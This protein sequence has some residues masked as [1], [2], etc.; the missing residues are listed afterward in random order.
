MGVWTCAPARNKPSE[1]GKTENKSTIVTANSSDVVLADMS[2][3]P[4]CPLPFFC[5]HQNDSQTSWPA[6][7]CAGENEQDMQPPP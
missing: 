5:A 7:I 1:S 3:K 2:S 4:S 6:L